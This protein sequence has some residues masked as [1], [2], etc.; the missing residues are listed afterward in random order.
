M[1]D[2]YPAGVPCWVD[3][4][5]ADPAVGVAFYSGLF[6]WEFEERVPGTYYLARL[7]GR[8]VAGVVRDEPVAWNTHVAVES[9]DATAA[10]A[11]EAGGKLLHGPVDVGD[12]GRAAVLADPVG[13]VF[14]A[15]EGRAHR[16]AEVVNEAGS[17]VSNDLYTPDVDAAAAFY[18]AVFGWEAS[19]M[20]FGDANDGYMWRRPGYAE[21]LETLEP[22]ITERHRREGAPEGFTDCVGWMMRDSGPARWGVSFTVEDPDATAAKALELG[23]SL[24]MPVF[25]AGPV[26]LAVIGDPGGGIFTA[27]RYQPE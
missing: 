6:G 14:T 1:R 20:D 4:A 16:G 27:T 11:V 15:W 2:H 18:G 21:F 7:D 19:V 8:T 3:C 22:G 12:R 5:Q 10:A 23:G 9:A 17:W 24:V 25:E 13:A 26:R